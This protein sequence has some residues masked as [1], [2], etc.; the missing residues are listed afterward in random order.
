MIPAIWEAAAAAAA[1]AQAPPAPL[2]TYTSGRQWSEADNAAYNNAV[3]SGNNA[4]ASALVSVRDQVQ[5]N[6]EA[7]HRANSTGP[8]APQGGGGGNAAADAA[9]EAARREAREAA[10]AWLTNI[11]SQ[12]GMS[13]MA[14][15][16]SNLIQQWGT[17]T[18]VIGLKLKDTAQY[19]DRFKGLLALQAKGIT[20]VNNEAEYIRLESDYRQAFRENGIQSFLGEAGSAVE[21]DKIADLVGNYSLSVNEVRDRISDAQRVAANTPQEV[22]EAFRDFYGIDEAGLVEYSLDPVGTAERFNRQANAAVA[23]GLARRQG[24]DAGRGVSEQIADLSGSQD[25]NAGYLTQ[26]LTDVAAVRDAT[27]RLADIEKGVLSDD[28]AISA[29]MNL[30]AEAEKKVKGLQSRERARFGGSSGFVTGSLS[31]SGGI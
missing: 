31:R 20:D 19:K 27:A 26:Q 8:Y 17:N 30:D 12:F 16:V 11:L 4:V 6:N 13:G 1:A 7:F 21:R 9:A 18:E 14:G 22:R 24:L 15:E 23:A 5:A 2:P 10:S 3:A 25:I 28:E 29:T